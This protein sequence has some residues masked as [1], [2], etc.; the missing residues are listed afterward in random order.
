[1]LGNDMS[2]ASVSLL[3]TF[4]SW[5]D[6][7]YLLQAFQMTVFM[8][9]SCYCGWLVQRGFLDSMLISAAI[10]LSL[11]YICLLLCSKGFPILL[12]SVV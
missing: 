2:M 4:S 3:F 6:C 1:M 9:G 5:E 7:E 10:F 11:V 12:Y 8:L